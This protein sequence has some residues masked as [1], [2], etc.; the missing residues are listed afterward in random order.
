M[1][2]GEDGSIQV[3]VPPLDFRILLTGA[4]ADMQAPSAPTITAT[5]GN[6]AL[7]LAPAVSSTETETVT[8][9]VT[10]TEFVIL[11]SLVDGGFTEIGRMPNEAG[12]VFADPDV[13]NGTTYYYQVQA[14]G[15][16]GLRSAPAN[17]GPLIPHAPILSVVI[18]E[19]LVLHHNLS[20]VERSPQSTAAVMAPGITEIAG[21]GAGLR[22]QIGWAPAGTDEFTW[23][24]GTYVT[25]NQGGANV[26][27]G[28]M[29]PETAGDY[30]FVW[31][32]TTTGGRDW[33]L[34]ENRGKLT[35]YPAADAEAPKPPFRLDAVGRSGSQVSF[36]WRVS[37]PPDLYNFRICRADL[38]AGESGCA[39]RID[40]PKESSVYTDTAVTAGSTYTYTVQAVDTS[41]N[42]SEPSDPITLT[43]E[44]S[45][46]DVTW[47]VLVPEATPPDDVIFIAGDNAEVFGASYNPGLQPMTPV[48]DN[49]WEYKARVQEGTRLLYKYTRGS[50]ESVEQ[51]GTISG[52][53]NR[54]L[55][56]VNGPDNTMLVDDTATDWGAEGPD[57]R[58]AVQS[59][60]DPLVAAVE[61]RANSSG[62]VATVRAE[63]A[64]L[65]SADAPATSSDCNG[66]CRQP[67]RRYCGAGGGPGLCVYPPP[68]VRLWRLHGYSSE[69]RDRHVYAGAVPVG[70]YRE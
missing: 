21:A 59:W 22:A 2:L 57:D 49:L 70:V 63:F 30:D 64:T 54:Q 29:L 61:P 58:R 39:T 40:V 34:S 28:T 1:T 51:W 44:L 16:N 32:A 37:R 65:I 48:G 10:V 7:S 66:C 47:R 13:A 67:R 6:R 69:R 15:E 68:A 43:A 3:V 36:A 18:D 12:A 38:T 26:Y 62:P 45:M 24:D 9:P 52:M 33:T 35:V 27:A 60:R 20:A 56:I 25:D 53:N 31:R 4:D 50:W 14:V 8:V 19:P 42:V 17:T 5:E 11:R 55:Q 46:V 41:F 23:A